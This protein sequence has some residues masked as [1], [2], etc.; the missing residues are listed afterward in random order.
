MIVFSARPAKVKEIVEIDL[1]KERT[2]DLKHTPR[3][4]EIFRHIWRLIEEES[5]RMGLLRVQ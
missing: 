5:T 2:L 3:F 1:P 4:M